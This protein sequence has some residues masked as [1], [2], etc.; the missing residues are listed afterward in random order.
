MKKLNGADPIQGDL[1]MDLINE[2]IDEIEALKR[3]QSEPV[4]LLDYFAGLAMQGHIS[5]GTIFTDPLYETRAECA[6]KMAQEML[7]V[8]SRIGF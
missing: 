3:T 2:M 8:K 1:T 5:A 6:Y 7:K 4:S